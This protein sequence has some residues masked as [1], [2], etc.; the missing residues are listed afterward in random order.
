[1]FVWDKGFGVWRVKAAQR[2]RLLTEPSAALWV[3]RTFS[4]NHF[5]AAHFWAAP[6]SIGPVEWVAPGLC[7]GPTPSGSAGSELFR[8]GSPLLGLIPR[9]T[10]SFCPN[11]S[12][13]FY[14][15]WALKKEENSLTVKNK[16]LLV[17]DPS[18]QRRRKQL[19]VK[20]KITILLLFNTFCQ[21]WSVSTNVTLSLYFS[22]K[23]LSALTLFQPSVFLQP[24]SGPPAGTF[25]MHL[26]LPPFF[27]LSSLLQ[28]IHNSATSLREGERWQQLP[29]PGSERRVKD[30]KVD[31]QSK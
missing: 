23:V 30:K 24:F 19:Q 27:L 31:L 10:S 15:H 13:C 4:S 22:S 12:K 29:Q 18:P 25:I 1:M 3:N 17:F 8:L 21:V 16:P 28:L 6:R 26:I 9:F 7:C 14:S 11:T 5:P 2:S 20:C